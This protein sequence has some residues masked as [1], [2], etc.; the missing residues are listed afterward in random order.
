MTSTG[1][2]ES[3]AATETASVITSATRSL[4]ARSGSSDS[5]TESAMAA[6][7][8]N[9]DASASKLSPALLETIV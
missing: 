5:M 7:T 4:L 8:A 3:G 1:T 9:T 6:A 2:F